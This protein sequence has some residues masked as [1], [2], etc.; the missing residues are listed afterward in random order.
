LLQSYEDEL[1]VDKDWTT[2][3]RA[4]T[5]KVL[6][7]WADGVDLSSAEQTKYR[8]GVG[9]CLRVMRWSRPEINNAT[10]G[11]SRFLTLGMSGAHMKAM[12]RVREYCVATEKEGSHL[13]RI[14]NSMEIQILR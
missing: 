9:K 12:Y 10:R 8:P 5:G 2:R 14:R 11:F 4:E 7:K 13:I 6:L 1:G 3:N